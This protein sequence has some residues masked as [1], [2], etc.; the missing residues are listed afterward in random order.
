MDAQIFWPWILA[1][2]TA[3]GGVVGF[4][5]QL[6]QVKQARLANEKLQ[7]EIDALKAERDERNSLVQV[8]TTEEVLMVRRARTRDHA[9]FARGGVN[10]GDD[11]GPQGAAPSPIVEAIV[12]AALLLLLLAFLGYL[13][14][15]LYRV[16]MWVIS[17]F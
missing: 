8:A 4:A 15:D 16:V 2:A 1:V 7:L 12:H 17:L 3:V 6:R 14:Y 10:P 5:I 11:G 13:A 9:A